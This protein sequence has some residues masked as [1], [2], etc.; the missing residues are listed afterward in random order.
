MFIFNKDFFLRTRK[1]LGGSW[2]ELKIHC[3]EIHTHIYSYIKG[4]PNTR[5]WVLCD[6]LPLLLL[7]SA[8]CDISKWEADRKIKCKLVFNLVGVARYVI[9]DENK[10]SIKHWKVRIY[11]LYDAQSCLY[12]ECVDKIK[13][14]RCRPQDPKGALRRWWGEMKNIAFCVIRFLP[15]EFRS[16]SM[17][18][19]R[20]NISALSRFLRSAA[21]KL[22]RKQI[23]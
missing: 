17:R 14:L 2:K 22:K 12:T 1:L 15:F 21:E 19:A 20:N 4:K 6:E 11:L 9:C 23:E 8:L 3:C 13:Y 10:G 18:K 16:S 5:A 7:R